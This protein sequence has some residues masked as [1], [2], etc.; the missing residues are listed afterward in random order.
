M[1]L[2]AQISPLE[3]VLVPEPVLSLAGRLLFALQLNPYVKLTMKK[4]GASADDEPIVM[5][6]RTRVIGG[7]N[8][9][10]K[11]N[12]EVVFDI[13]CYQKTLSLACYDEDLLDED[14]TIGTVEV[15]LTEA[16]NHQGETIEK[17]VILQDENVAN[18]GEVSRRV[19]RQTLRAPT[20]PVHV[21]RACCSSDSPRLTIRRSP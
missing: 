7:G 19:N 18:R 3:S 11:W 9:A 21:M 1:Y 6:R 4:Q 8:T 16:L 13:D 5:D 17:T 2:N 12:Q 14:E 20:H 15:D 10:P